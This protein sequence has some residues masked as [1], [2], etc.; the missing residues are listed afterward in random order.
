MYQP[1]PW[2]PQQ[3]FR[4][5]E[6]GRTYKAGLGARGLYDQSKVNERFYVGDQW[7]G[8]RCGNERPLVRHNVVKRI[9]D[10]KMAM[11]TSTPVTVQY[12]AEGIPDTPLIQER[13]RQARRSLSG[14]VPDVQAD[15]DLRITGGSGALTADPAGRSGSGR[16]MEAGRAGTAGE[17][18]PHTADRRGGSGAVS[19]DENGRNGTTG[20]PGAT[21]ATG[22]PGV[23]GKEARGADGR[24][25]PA[26]GA[27]FAAA[28]GGDRASGKAAVSGEPLASGALTA[29]HMTG[30][31]A[32]PAHPMGGHGFDGNGAGAGMGAAAFTS[33]TAVNAPQKSLAPE[34]E[35]SLVMAALTDYFRTTAERVKLDDLKEQALRNA[36]ISGTGVLYSYWDPT[37]PTGQYADQGH[38]VPI[39][40]DIACE[41]LDIENV[42]FGD[43]T[44]YD[45]Q[46]Q[47]Y[48]LIAQ[49]KSVEE[50]RRMAK[51]YGRPAADI[52]AI[53]PDGET[54]Y[55]AGD[56][57]ADEPADSRKATVL[58]KL[59]REYDDR[60]NTKIRAAMAVRGATIR[61]PWDTRLRLYPLA[62]FRWERRRSCAYGESEITYLIPNQIAI[63]R[64]LTAN[65]WA[66]MMLGMPLTLVNRDIL[67]QP[68]TNDPGQILELNGTPEEM[69]GAVRYVQP[70]NFS[71]AFDN[72]IASLIANTLTQS[73]ANDAALGDIRPDNAAAIV[74]VREAATL[75]MQTVQNRFYSFLEDVAR[76][77]AEMW[78]SLY[79]RRALRIEDENG[80]WYMPFDGQKYRDLLIHVKIDVGASTLWSEIQSSQTLDNLLKMQV[81]TPLQYLKR[82]PK[83]TVPDVGGLIREL[84]EAQRAQQQAAAGMAAA[85]ASQEGQSARP[86]RS[87]KNAA[88]D[89]ASSEDSASGETSAVSGIPIEAVLEALPEEYRQIFE[90]LPPTQQQALLKE[91]G[92]IA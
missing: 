57:A 41:V 19:A 4:D 58:T 30:G 27:G 52:A 45:L 80:V 54:Q 10:Y 11:V 33:G 28:A 6:A 29:S 91:S 37:V 36:Y 13:V 42:Y 5:Y 12:S 63:N 60:G 67:Q 25:N 76:I 51:Q 89:S 53:K 88:E 44:L 75:P 49:R 16:A 3:M 26:A 83:G 31:A 22:A 62:A 46:Q 70:P 48:I 8:A 79:G 72:N 38:T 40:G 61:A 92:V 35:T 59:W 43:P 90:A 65:V 2:D 78:V 7:Y 1:K 56:R 66:I 73:G 50:L 34:E 15:G 14:N 64:M 9:G 69:A 24:M 81:I 86:A 47:P 71:P 77:W 87:A 84:Q 68:V 39:R 18:E 17:A 23:P 21:G 20:V 74:A 82:L 32:A 55:M 85:Q